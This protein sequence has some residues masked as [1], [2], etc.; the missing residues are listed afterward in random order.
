MLK[1]IKGISYVNIA[2]NPGEEYAMN[3]LE[4]VPREKSLKVFAL[5]AGITLTRTQKKTALSILRHLPPTATPRDFTDACSS[6]STAA[7]LGIPEERLDEL[8][9]FVRRLERLL[10]PKEM[11]QRSQ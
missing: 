7:S 3:P 6:R 2:D 5:I 1:F 11:P 10:F 8:T 9:L 4:N